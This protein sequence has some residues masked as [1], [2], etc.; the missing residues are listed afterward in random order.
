MTKVVALIHIPL[1]IHYFH[2]CHGVMFVYD[3]LT[4]AYSYLTIVIYGQSQC[5]YYPLSDMIE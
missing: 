4:S 2:S 1:V 3:D 5:S